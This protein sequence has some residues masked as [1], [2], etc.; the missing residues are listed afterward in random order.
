MWW[1]R[2]LSFLSN[3]VFVA[4]SGYGTT[5]SPAFR[6]QVGSTWVDVSCVGCIGSAWFGVSRVCCIEHFFTLLCVGFACVVCVSISIDYNAIGKGFL[7]TFGA[8]LF[9]VRGIPGT[10]M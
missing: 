4:A 5:A 9:S 1:H 8:L 6:H 7:K 2:F 10:N 3:A